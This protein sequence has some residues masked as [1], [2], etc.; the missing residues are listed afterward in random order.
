MIQDDQGRYWA[1]G[2]DDGRWNVYDGEAWTAAD[3]LAYAG[4]EAGAPGPDVA[5]P[6]VPGAGE[7][8]PSAPADVGP[9]TAAAP[10]GG[11]W[12]KQIRLVV[13]TLAVL[14]LAYLGYS[15]YSGQLG[16]GAKTTPTV[17]AV[18]QV[19][20]S[21]AAPTAT[22]VTPTVLVATPTLQATPVGSA[23][24]YLEYILDG[25]ESMMQSLEGKTKLDTAKEVLSSRMTYL[26]PAINVGLRVYGHRQPSQ[27][28]EAAS[29]KDIEL[30]VPVAQGGAQ[31]IIGWLPGMKAQGMTPIS[32]ALKQAAEDFTFEAGRRNSIIL[33]SDGLETCGEDPALA[34]K[35]LRAL[36]IDYTI[37]VIG[38]GVDDDAKAQLSAIAEASSG[39]Y[40]DAKG[41][42]DLT[43]ALAEVEPI[44]TK[45]P[46]PATSSGS[47][48]AKPTVVV[49]P[50][51]QPSPTATTKPVQA[52]TAT[53][54]QLP[55][56]TAAATPA[57]PQP[58]LTNV[59]FSDSFSRA[60]GDRCAL[61]AADQPFG[62]TSTR[63]Y[64][65]IFPYNNVPA[66]P[67]GA[68][69]ANGALQNDY[70]DFGGVQFAS[71]SAVCSG[72]RG[73]DMGQ[74]LDIR[75]DLLVPGDAS[76]LPTAAGPYIRSRAAAGGDG[77][78]GGESA[79]YWI[80]LYSTG[81]VKIKRLSPQAFVAVSGAPASFDTSVFH[82]LEIAAQGSSL[83]VALDGRLLTFTQ[84]GARVTTVAIPLTSG[85]NNGTAG[86][87]FSAE[88][89]RGKLGGQR[90]DNLVVAA[91]RSLSGLPVQSN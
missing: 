49:V 65:P 85:N 59:V 14:A 7:A 84:D 36:G 3:P 27:G 18:A 4:A 83:Q 23:N 33:I 60:A 71:T 46:P 82:T 89:N 28:N 45:L 73:A 41:Q 29:C 20:T 44:V 79:G 54:A 77:I 10:S 90:A 19:A 56:P 30:V 22:A 51:S 24:I 31:R 81:E 57:A 40:H 2:A 80:Q 64:L 37:H 91:Y 74:N 75:V 86:I 6:G 15:W 62:G 8:E 5:E 78:I 25:S 72:A 87:G 53:P 11:F 21:T 13:G 55:N 32:A 43:T 50:V 52:P 48:T 88:T 1:L 17:T 66:N 12:R 35:A 38:L 63:Y 42:M 9:D 76:G 16:G 70:Q 39:T 26:P 61:G 68:S 34:V 47:G 69:I 58:P 67:I